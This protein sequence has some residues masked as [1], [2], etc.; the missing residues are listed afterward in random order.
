MGRCGYSDAAG[1]RTHSFS[2]RVY[3]SPWGRGPSVAQLAVKEK[4]AQRK[5]SKDYQES[6]KAGVFSISEDAGQ[7]CF[8]PSKR[9]RHR[10]PTTNTIQGS[11]E[12]PAHPLHSVEN[13]QNSQNSVISLN[14]PNTQNTQSQNQNFGF[15]Q[16]SSVFGHT[17]QQKSSLGG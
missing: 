2:C 11:Y 12:P 6:F 9:A 5:R 1:T 3:T 17:S 13:Y 10:A 7:G 14:G 4:T 15:V 8:I 16:A